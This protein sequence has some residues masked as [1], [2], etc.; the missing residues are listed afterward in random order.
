MIALRTSIGI[1]LAVVLASRLSAAPPALIEVQTGNETL[2]GKVIAHDDRLF[3]LLAQDGRMRPLPADSV[4][5]FRQIAPQFSGSSS[6][7]L[8]DSLRR[9][10]GKTFEVVGTRHYAVCA[11]GDQKARVYAETFEELFRTFQLYFSVRGFKV[12]EPEFPLVAIVFPDYESF[13]NYA[14]AEKVAPSRNLHGYYLTTSNRIALYE[15]PEGDGHVLR[16][17]GDSRLDLLRDDSEMWG[18]FE[19]SLKDTLI[20]E[21]THQAA[22]N[23][24]LHSR[25]GPNPKWIVEGLATVFEAPG[26]RNPGSANVKTRINRERY[27]WF[28]DYSKSRRK[29]KS[30]ESFVTGDELFQSSVLDAYSEAWAFSF[31]LIE[32]RPRAYAEYLRTIAE[33]NPL[34]AYPPDQRL[35]DFKKAVSS[36][37]PVLEAEYLR[38][39]ASIK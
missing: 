3:W 8:R 12:T 21:A 32:T 36:D 38:F 26:I 27:V 22:F 25:I 24:G 15:A 33:R 31:F 4:R 37:L 29:P 28:S 17:P 10:L 20:H 9:E 19:G 39:L 35:A 2:Q 11:Q 16:T 14:R 5:K 30:L 34:R 1:F 23:T 13:A 7:V 6:S 18:K